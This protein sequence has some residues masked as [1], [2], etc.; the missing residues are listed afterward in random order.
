VDTPTGSMFRTRK[1][2]EEAKQRGDL[3]GYFGK[4]SRG[5][6]KKPP[7]PTQ[8]EETSLSSPKSPSP[9]K[10]PKVSWENP[11]NFD[12]LRRAVEH[13]LGGGEIY[14]PPLELMHVPR[15]TVLR[16]VAE[17]K[18]ASEDHSI[19]V[20]AVTRGMAYTKGQSGKVG[21]LSQDDLDFLCGCIRHRD[22]C[23]RGMCRSEVIN[24]IMELEQ[25]S[26][27]KK[28][29]NHF[30][31]I[32]LL[33]VPRNNGERIQGCKGDHQGRRR[34]KETLQAHNKLRCAD[35]LGFR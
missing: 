34:T 10:R 26:D 5:R 3:R 16:K 35:A 20:G 8:Q 15:T 23:N 33:L 18:K 9:T 21:L 22:A 24:M 32:F 25:T 30:H 12:T 2:K 31:G 19:P 28:C 7:P 17:F 4:V 27:R 11:E 6:P 1:A 14:N 13:Y 29:E